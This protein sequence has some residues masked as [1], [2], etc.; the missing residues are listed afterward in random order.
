MQENEL[1]TCPTQDAACSLLQSYVA[2]CSI[3]QFRADANELTLS[4]LFSKPKNESTLKGAHALKDPSCN[5]CLSEPYLLNLIGQIPIV[6][7]LSHDELCLH[8][9]PS[10]V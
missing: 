4:Q 2:T 3:L 9:F 1:T 6:Q 8:H 10:H 7:H 5:T